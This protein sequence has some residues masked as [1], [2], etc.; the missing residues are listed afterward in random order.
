MKMGHGKPKDRRFWLGRTV[1]DI[2]RTSRIAAQL[3]ETEIQQPP[4][5]QPW[6]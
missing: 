4:T 3:T 6:Q 2:E 5:D 1:F